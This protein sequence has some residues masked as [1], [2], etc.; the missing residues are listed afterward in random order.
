MTLAEE[1]R[2]N[3]ERVASLIEHTNVDPA[4]TRDEIRTLCDEVL[5]Y[6]FR[7]GVVVP[8]HA[9]FAREC[10]GDRATVVAVVGFPYGVQNAAAKRTE[11]EE[12]LDDVDEL[13]LVMHRTAFANRDDETVVEDVR[14]VSD[15]CGETT[16]KCIIE[17]P[18]LSEE[19]IRRTAGLVEQGGADVVKTAV[20]YDG[21]TDPGAVRTI[22]E[23]VGP[24]VG[25]K[26]SG[27]ID[28]FETALAMVEAGATHI[29]AS[30]GVEIVGSIPE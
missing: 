22:R 12:L 27:G 28:D 30:A 3:P 16:L 4:A 1:L 21:P 9:G 6:G 26:A 2:E 19:E 14:A 29:G 25:I 13:D 11:A 8:Y 5:E 20:G 10:L 17:A 7:A 18:A 15:R 24:D 23:T